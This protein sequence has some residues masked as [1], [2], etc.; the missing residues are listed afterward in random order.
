MKSASRLVFQRAPGALL[1]SG[2][3]VFVWNPGDWGGVIE[4][5]AGFDTFELIRSNPSAA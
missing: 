2:D 1:G 5:R 3:D 4:G